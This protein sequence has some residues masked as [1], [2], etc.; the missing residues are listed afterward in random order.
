MEHTRTER[1]VLGSVRHPFIVGLHYAFQTSK[2]LYFI[3]DYCPGGDMFFHLSRYGCFP[4][5]MAKFY[6]AEIALALV[7]LHELGVIYRDLKPENIMLDKDGHVKLA[8][9]GL[10]KEGIT[11]DAE[12]TFTMCGTPEYLPPEILNRNG[13]GKAVDWWNL[14]MVLYELLTGRPPWYTTDRMKLFLRLRNAKLEF[15]SGMSPEAMSFIEGLLN[16]NPMQRLGSQSPEQILKH[17]FFNGV[18][19]RKLYNREVRPPYL[20]S[21]TSDPESTINF[22][23]AFTQIPVEEDEEA[24]SI[25][26]VSTATPSGRGS[27]A[28][29]L[30]YTFQGFTYEGIDD[31]FPVQ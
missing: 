14:G 8:D 28:R 17:P 30:S 11:S 2:K 15:P 5:I 29:A 20:P 6:A 25:G 7:H 23:P 16:R 19:W 4:E 3:L 22:E 18:N 12:G 13:H 24:T 26:H 27:A 1:R 31:K 9:F 21:Q 10:A